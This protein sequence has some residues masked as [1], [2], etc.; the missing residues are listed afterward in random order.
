MG[1]C[2]IKGHVAIRYSHQVMVGM[3]KPLEE[4]ILIDKLV[5]DECHNLPPHFIYQA[6]IKSAHEAGTPNCLR[7]TG[8]HRVQCPAWNTELQGMVSPCTP[9]G[10]AGGLLTNDWM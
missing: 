1:R 4:H 5:I 10:L 9:P 8:A 7:S 3:R 6:D 2:H